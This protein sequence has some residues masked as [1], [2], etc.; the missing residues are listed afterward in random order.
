MS[1]EP[2][3]PLARH[4]HVS[5]LEIPSLDPEKSA[6]FYEAVFGWQINARETGRPS[7]DDRS[8]NFIGRWI[9][10]RAPAKDAGIMPYI[11]VVGIDNTVARVEANGGK[12][13][14]PPYPEGD[15]WVATFSDPAGNV[16]GIWQFSP[17]KPE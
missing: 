10:H 8:G 16:L 7:F 4:G 6:A 5:Y 9:K 2:V 14:R 11:Y 13:I 17:R 15:L 12:I 3:N 1:S